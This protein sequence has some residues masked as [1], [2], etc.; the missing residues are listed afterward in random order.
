MLLNEEQLLRLKGWFV[1]D[2]AVRTKEM[3]HFSCR[4]LKESE[5]ASVLSDN[6]VTKREFAIYLD[7]PPERYLGG[8]PFTG[9]EK[10]FVGASSDHITGK[11][12]VVFVDMDG[13]VYARGDAGHNGIEEDILNTL[14]GPRRGSIFRIRMI[15]GRLYFAGDMNAVGYRT[16]PNNWHSLCLNLPV[17]KDKK[18]WKEEGSTKFEFNDI[19]GFSHD[20]LYAVG[21]KGNLW[22][23]NGQQ[24]EELTL[25]SNLYTHSI[26]CAG[27]GFVYIGAQSG[28]LFK[29]RGNQWKLIYR[30]DYSL[31]FKDMVWHDD[32][33][34]C[35]SDYGLWCV[36][37]D[38]LV[39]ANIPAEIKVCSGNLSTADGVM[40][41]AGM[42]GAAYHDGKEWHLIFNS[43][44]LQEDE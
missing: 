18:Q 42:F 23:Y 35:T 33:L 6:E 5:K 3:F 39:D 43:L 25:P 41:M 21:G 31:P 24:W 4:N 32:K 7:E 38:K 34:W 13:S 16:G 14:N 29:G 9:F 11:N 12:E 8:R 37:D 27:D 26:C 44:E 40:L 22:H 19:D 2:C 28:S 1:Y 30:G 15:C 17:P 10:L 36:K 20:D